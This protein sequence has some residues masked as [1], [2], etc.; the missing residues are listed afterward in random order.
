MLIVLR[1]ARSFI[2]L[3]G[4]VALA[5]I[6]GVFACANAASMLEAVLPYVVTLAADYARFYVIS[7]ILL[8]VIII[9]IA[10]IIFPIESA[11]TSGVSVFLADITIRPSLVI[12]VSIVIVTI[13]SDVAVVRII[14]IIM[15]GIITIIRVV[16]IV[17]RFFAD[18][19]RSV[20]RVEKIGCISVG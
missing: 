6:R 1:I 12:V 2:I 3:S 7:V 18:N 15:M 16:I 20:L 17:L 4:I 14:F 10:V 9:I 5:V 13:V 8:L 19:W 11:V